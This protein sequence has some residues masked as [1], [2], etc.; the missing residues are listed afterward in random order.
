MYS[1]QMLLSPA[2]LAAA[3]AAAAAAALPPK[4]K[5]SLYKT[6]VCRS[7]SQQGSCP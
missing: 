5:N 3:A 7:F 6:E 2:A 1:P 4:A